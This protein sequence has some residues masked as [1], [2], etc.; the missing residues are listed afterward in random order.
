MRA[1]QSKMIEDYARKYQE[2]NRPTTDFARAEGA[3][4]QKEQPEEDFGDF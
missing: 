1:Q 2:M 3:L 4:K